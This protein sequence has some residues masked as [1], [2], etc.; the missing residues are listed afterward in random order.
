MKTVLTWC[1]RIIAAVLG[2]AGI[3]MAI[4]AA[5]SDWSSVGSASTPIEHAG[6]AAAAFSLLLLGC[7]I[8][9]LVASS[10]HRSYSAKIRL[11][12]PLFAVMAIGAVA[13]RYASRGA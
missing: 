8:I 10:P 3:A 11:I 5:E 13:F 4:V 2:A 7:A 9:A 12:T 6:I 1:L